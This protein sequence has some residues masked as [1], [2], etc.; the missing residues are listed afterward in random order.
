MTKVEAFIYEQAEKE[1]AIL[2]YFHELFLS[3]NLMP[4][5]RYKIPFY[6]RKK[7]LCY[8]N[9]QKKGGVELVFLRGKELSNAQ[10]ILDDK[11]RKQVSGI[12]FSSV[13]DIPHEA[14]YEIIQEA[15]LLEET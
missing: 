14:V 4:K 9:P 1:R 5:I 10:G 13:T 6:Y 8:L 12:F 15:I 2:L 11:G 7:W 3:L